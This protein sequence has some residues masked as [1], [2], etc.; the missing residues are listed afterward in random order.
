MA[1][2]RWRLHAA[3]PLGGLSRAAAPLL[4]IR[5]LQG[6]VAWVFFNEYFS[7]VPGSAFWSVQGAFIAYLLLNLPIALFYRRGRSST[8][9]LA[10]DLTVN[11]ATT[12]LVIAASGGTSSALLL[13]VPLQSVPYALVFGPLVALSFLLGAGA[14]LALVELASGFGLLGVP[15]GALASGSVDQ[16][17]MFAAVEALVSGPLATLWLGWVRGGAIRPSRPAPERDAT[18]AAVANALLTVSE[19]VSSLTRLDEILA[20]VAEVAPRS[21]QMDYCSIALWTEETGK[22]V[23]AVAS[24]T[25]ENG[26]PTPVQLS[27]E[28]VLNFEWVRRLGHCAVVPVADS[29]QLVPID[30]PAVL[31]T[32]LESGDHFFGVVE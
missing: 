7:A 12:G 1:L 20:A 4:I 22:Y 13:L 14:L 18:P 3:G 9:A 5:V 10:G 29:G 28:Q 31:I 27:P 8:A 15:V 2:L 17:A 6:L 25:D 32:P 24:G 23:R 30:V 26:A 11:I 21:I 19:A 16:V